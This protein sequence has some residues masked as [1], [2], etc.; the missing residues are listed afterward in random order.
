MREIVTFHVGNCGNQI[1]RQF[2]ELIA[3]EHG[4]DSGGHF[5]GHHQ[6]QAER[7]NVYFN[8]GR[9]RFIARAVC[10][11]GDPEGI[12]RLQNYP[13]G[14]LF[15]PE[16]MVAGFSS[17]DNNF[18]KG[19]FTE[20]AELMDIVLESARKEAESC[21]LLQG[22]QIV[23]SIGG[24]TGSGTTALLVKNLAEE[25]PDNLISTYTVIPSPKV[26]N[27]VVEPYN[28]IL[29]LPQL[30]ENTHMTCCYDND[31]LHDICVKT[32][33]L[34]AASYNDMNFIISHTIAGLTAC[35]RFPGQ[36]NSDLHKL[37]TN[38]VPFPNYHFFVPSFAPLMSTHRAKMTKLTVAEIVY[39]VFNSNNWLVSCDTARGKFLTAAAVFRGRMSPKE[40]DVQMKNVQRKNQNYFVEWIPNNIK[41]AIC[42][43]PPKGLKMSAT[44]IANITSVQ[45][46]FH[47]LHK[48]FDALFRRRGHVHWY[49]GEGMEE[50]EII[51][52]GNS[53]KQFF[54]GYQGLE[55]E[56]D[57]SEESLLCGSLDI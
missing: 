15:N 34:S 56:K 53:V 3:D 42:D 37:Y 21:D 25:Y 28:S 39:Q 4:I 12:A 31:A 43:I 50:A 8:E 32:L 13:S 9:N 5:V 55:A 41:S 7:L 1:G 22:F 11:D 24:G 46:V 26:S 51:E 2:W 47:R 48:Q 27:I 57:S 14:K 29:G 6:L 10:L 23:H 33:K 19:Y 20:G 18:A 38:M 54:K 36:L 40:V 44:F 52:A 16:N 35:F 30:I 45:H 17:N 49:I